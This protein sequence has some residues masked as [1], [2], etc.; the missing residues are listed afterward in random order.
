MEYD[1]VIIGSSRAAIQ[2]AEKATLLGA[3]VALVTQTTENYIENN[4]FFL[5]EAT[6]LINQVKYN[7]WLFPTSLNNNLEINFDLVN[8]INNSHIST[9]E[10]SLYKLAIFGVD[11]I[12]GKGEFCRQPKQAFIIGSRKLRSRNYLIALN[13]SIKIDYIPEDELLTYYIN[14]LWQ[15]KNL[16]FL[17][18]R[19]AIVGNSAV[20]LELAQVL[21]RIGKKVTL[22]ISLSRILPEEELAAAMLIQAQLEAEGIDII[23]NS[24]VSQIKK[25]EGETWLQAGN[26]ALIVD[27][28]I[29]PENIYCDFTELNLLGIRDVEFSPKGI[30]VNKKLQTGNKN[31]YACGQ[32]TGVFSSVIIEQQINII[33]KNILLLPCFS[34]DYTL[35]PRIVSTNPSLAS[36]GMIETEAKK[37]HGDKIYI[38]REYFKNIIQ[39]QISGQTTGWCQFII[40]SQGK[41]LGCTIVGDRAQELISTIAVI[42]HHKLKLSNHP[43]QGLLKTEIITIES[44]LSAILQKTVISFQ[45]QKLQRQKNKLNWLKTWL[46]IKRKF[47]KL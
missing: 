24:S 45:K 43:I 7:P 44:S 11:V 22:I 16:T 23:T 15:E 13:S 31:I 8:R 35:L 37:N 47:S 25:I 6:N 2:A 9:V 4:Y 18:T 28:V 27:S 19:L 5:K 14:D 42:M 34:T 3:R 20:S 33:L 30:T 29:Y 10:N 32:S 1:L 40:N 12:W 38:V 39:S 46:K 41:I 17:G 26:K 36:I 21:R